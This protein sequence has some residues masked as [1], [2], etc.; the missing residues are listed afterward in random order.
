MALL[1]VPAH[2]V[3]LGHQVLGL[4]QP[5]PPRLVPQQEV[6]HLGPGIQL[7]HL[8]REDRVL[9]GVAVVAVVPEEVDIANVSEGTELTTMGISAKSCLFLLQ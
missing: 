2:P 8:E 6:V 7:A 5:G 1:A 3:P 9:L 4:L